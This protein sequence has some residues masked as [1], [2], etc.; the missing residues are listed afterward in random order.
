MFGLMR[1]A[2]RDKG[3][4]DETTRRET[5][6]KKTKESEMK[7]EIM[8][9]GR[10][11]CIIFA[12]KD[13]FFEKE[14]PVDWMIIDR[15]STIRI[16]GT[17]QGI[18]QIQAN[19]PTGETILDPIEYRLKIPVAAIH[20]RLECSDPSNDKFLPKIQEAAKTLLA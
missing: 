11:L 4:S 1:T 8:M 9:F 10:G 18:G 15:A 2:S 3:Y 13:F 20:A 19:G 16:W 6:S 17:T 5:M 7:H 14:G 12:K